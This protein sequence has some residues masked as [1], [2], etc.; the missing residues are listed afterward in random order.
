MARIRRLTT[1]TRDG[2]HNAFTDLIY[3]HDMYVV[4]YRKGAGHISGD[5][6]AVVAISSDRQRFTE[7][8]RVKVN[9]DTRDPKLVPLADGRLA[10]LIAVWIEGVAARKLQQF[11]SFSDDACNWSRPQPICEPDQ[12]LWRVRLHEGR[13]YGLQYGAMPGGSLRREETERQHQLMV[14]EDMLHWQ[15]VARIGPTDRL[16]GESDIAFQEDGEAWVVVRSNNGSGN[17]FFASARPPY[18]DWAVTELEGGMIHAPVILR[19]RGV[20]YVAGRARLSDMGMSGFSQAG[21]ATTGVWRLDK[22]RVT[23]VLNL[24]AA[25]DCSYCGLIEDPEGRVCLSYYSQHAYIFG[26]EPFAYRYH[27]DP[28]ERPV[29]DL[30]AKADIYFAELELP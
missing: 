18:T 27:D 14:S 25:G 24:P 1:L 12:W 7:V 26:V 2:M 28:V 13:Y 23:P 16:L 19:H 20:H 15:S 9:G 17:A 21:T 3:W 8:A 29:G 30:I 5:G 10:M 22:G 6:Q 4:S 11:I